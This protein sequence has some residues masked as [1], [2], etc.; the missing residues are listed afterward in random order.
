MQLWG[1][2]TAILLMGA[3]AAIPRREHLT[4]GPPPLRPQETKL[5]S[6]VDKRG[7]YGTTNRFLVASRLWSLV[8]FGIPKGGLTY[9]LPP[10][11]LPEDEIEPE[12]DGPC[13]TACGSGEDGERRCAPALDEDERCSSH[14]SCGE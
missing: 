6:G 7:D 2:L 3:L 9:G 11:E 4:L 5:P 1:S 12:P 10:P 14:N 13:R 8:R